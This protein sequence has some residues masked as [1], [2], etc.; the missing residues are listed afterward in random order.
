MSYIAQRDAIKAIVQARL[1]AMGHL[2]LPDQTAL[3]R[4]K[5]TEEVAERKRHMPYAARQ[6]LAALQHKL[7]DL[8]FEQVWFAK[9]F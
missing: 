7:S 3:V 8:P 1:P 4:A 9:T 6:Q 2:R 5:F